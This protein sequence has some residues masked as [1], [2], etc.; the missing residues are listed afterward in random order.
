ML[1][2]KSSSDEV[3]L[4]VNNALKKN[5]FGKNTKVEYRFILFVKNLRIWTM[6]DVSP[7]GVIEKLTEGFE[8]E[9]TIDLPPLEYLQ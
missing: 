6:E 4:I 7:F 5:Y 2:D 8:R 3:F 9:T 1:N